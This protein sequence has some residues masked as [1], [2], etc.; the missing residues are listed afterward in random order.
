MTDLIDYI[1]PMKSLKWLEE[2]LKI[3]KSKKVKN[4]IKTLRKMIKPWKHQHL[5]D[6]KNDDQI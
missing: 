2:S 5:I 4:K 1:K 6:D 3:K